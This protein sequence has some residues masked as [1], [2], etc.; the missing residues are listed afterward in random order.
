MLAN[1]DLHGLE[2]MRLRRLQLLPHCGRPPA[3]QVYTRGGTLDVLQDGQGG[4]YNTNTAS[5]TYQEDL[6]ISLTVPNRRTGVENWEKLFKDANTFDD[7]IYDH[8]SDASSIHLPHYRNVV[9]DHR[10]L[11]H[12]H[13][14]NRIPHRPLRPNDEIE[15]LPAVLSIMK[16]SAT[17]LTSLN[18]DWL[19]I[20]GSHAF[21]SPFH[22]AKAFDAFAKIF[23]LRFPCLRAFQL[24]NCVVEEC[25][26]PPGLFL[27]DDCFMSEPIPQKTGK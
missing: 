2:S 4:V 16:A 13:A 5:Y 18:L 24:R 1:I 21:D 20:R 14:E 17:T 11:V 12:S 23:S 15:S 22:V 9:G 3:Q 10:A 19:L 27:L 25:K 6:Y 26:L 7:M 8:V